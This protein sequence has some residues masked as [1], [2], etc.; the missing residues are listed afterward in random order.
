VALSLTERTEHA[1]KSRFFFSLPCIQKT[2]SMHGRRSGLISKVPG[3]Q[4]GRT[5]SP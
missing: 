5:Q 2:A 1:E 3:H 4:A